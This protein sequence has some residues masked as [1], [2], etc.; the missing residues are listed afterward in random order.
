[1]VQDE[2]KLIGQYKAGF[3]GEVPKVFSQ[4]TPFEIKPAYT[5]EQRDAYGICAQESHP[6]PTAPHSK[7]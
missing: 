3:T 2:T 1:M 6:T 7:N 5:G 4:P